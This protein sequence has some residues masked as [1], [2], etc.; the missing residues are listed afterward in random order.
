MVKER[1]DVIG[2]VVIS[3][4]SS[5]SKIIDYSIFILVFMFNICSNLY[6]KYNKMQSCPY[7]LHSSFK[8]Y[9]V[10]RGKL[11][12]YKDPIYII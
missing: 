4:T 6:Q 8:K 1:T 10:G 11:F 2:A 3:I 5:T 12:K 7:M 9:F